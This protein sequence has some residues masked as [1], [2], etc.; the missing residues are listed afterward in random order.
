MATPEPKLV[1]VQTAGEPS[2]PAT[3][4]AVEGSS[5][6]PG[7]LVPDAAWARTAA[8]PLLALYARTNA[9]LAQRG[10]WGARLAEH[11]A[12][13]F[14]LALAGVLLLAPRFLLLG[15][16]AVA[17]LA[18]GGAAQLPDTAAV[19]YTPNNIAIILGAFLVGFALPTRWR[20]AFGLLVSAWW[21]LVEFG[22]TPV[23]FAIYAVYVAALFGLAKLP[24][25][26]YA[27]FAIG[28]ALAAGTYAFLSRQPAEAAGGIASL[29]AQMT[30]IVPLIWYT[31][32]AEVPGRRRL[33]PLQHGLYHYLRLLRAP[34]LTFKDVFGPTKDSLAQIRFEGFKTLYTVLASVIVIDLIGRYAARVN[35]A[36]LTGWPMLSYAYLHYV[37]SHLVFVVGINTVI[38]GLRLF[39]VPVRD[40][41]NHWLLARTPNEHW[42]RWN[43]L[44]REWIVSFIFFPLMRS[45]RGLFLAVMASLIGSGLLH[46]MPRVLGVATE[47]RKISIIMAYWVVNGIAIYAF[48]KIPQAAPRLVERLGMRTNRLWWAAGIAFTSAFYGVL[49]HAR[50]SCDTWDEVGAY[51]QRLLGA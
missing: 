39:G 42:R 47:W 5:T 23:G 9:A 19:P 26:R 20:L 35:E 18:T 24:L 16:A 31:M 11:H 43:V 51:F 1:R 28:V 30:M 27:V 4:E 3:T 40:N 44:M 12:L 10:G 36:E 29:M 22:V 17:K 32:T 48:I 21:P 41:F 46:I 49:V 37:R 50:Y 13:L 6:L 2:P 14:A 45:R 7:F 25:S 8:A 34:V 15:Y 33:K 38:A